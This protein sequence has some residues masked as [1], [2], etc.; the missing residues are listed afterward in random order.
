MDKGQEYTPAKK[1]RKPPFFIRP[2]RFPGNRKR[3]L[4]GA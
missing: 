1:N 2:Y 4:I 3:W